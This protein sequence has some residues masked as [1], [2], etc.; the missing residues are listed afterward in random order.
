MGLVNVH[1]PLPQNWRSGAILPRY[2]TL[3]PS[4]NDA[5]KSLLWSCAS[6][7]KSVTNERRNGITFY[8]RNFQPQMRASP[9][10]VRFETHSSAE[11][12]LTK[13]DCCARNGCGR[14]VPFRQLPRTQKLAPAKKI[15]DRSFLCVTRGAQCRTLLP[16]FWTFSWLYTPLRFDF[17]A[18]RCATR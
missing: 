8:L 17:R 18:N 6:T 15:C 10:S 7:T 1:P 16:M 4:E 11:L 2:C 5:L 12:M 13:I 3:I 14:K 9:L